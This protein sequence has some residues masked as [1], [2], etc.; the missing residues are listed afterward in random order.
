MFYVIMLLIP[1]GMIN[2][3]VA[4]GIMMNGGYDWITAVIQFAC[5]TLP[6]G[7]LIYAATRADDSETCRP[8]TQCASAEST[9]LRHWT[10][11][12]HANRLT[13]SDNLKR[14]VRTAI[15]L[16]KVAPDDRA[17]IDRYLGELD[18]LARQLE[19]LSGDPES[20]AAAQVRESFET[21]VRDA[22]GILTARRERRIEKHAIA[23]QA[24]A[25]VFGALN[26]EAHTADATPVPKRRNA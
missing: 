10:L 14:L 3:F 7:G 17:F 26:R 12:T 5:T 6:V 22:L 16:E 18:R 25:D 4:S 8:D 19:T 9:P 11:Y 1:L 24:T 15:D 13:A 2:A 23:F 20:A 21:S